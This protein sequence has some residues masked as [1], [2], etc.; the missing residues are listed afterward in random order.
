MGD[1][2]VKQPETFQLN[3]FYLVGF[4]KDGKNIPIFKVKFMEYDENNREVREIFAEGQLDDLNR[5]I[6][7]RFKNSYVRLDSNTASGTLD[8]YGYEVPT[9][10]LTNGIKRKKGGG[11]RSKKMRRNRKQ[12]KTN[13]RRKTKGFFY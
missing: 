6:R 4:S 7:E 8:S 9:D 2:V 5:R 11:G 13:R 1:F 10:F 3:R 12:R